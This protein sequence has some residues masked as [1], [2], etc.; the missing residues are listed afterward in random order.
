MK[1]KS[2][3]N[4]LTFDDFANYIHRIVMP[5][6]KNY[7]RCEIVEDRYFEGSLKEGIRNNRGAG[8][9]KLIFNDESLMPKDFR[10]NFFANSENKE[11]LN[12]VLAKEFVDFDRN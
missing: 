4:C 2:R 7:E 12:I 6:S 1:S 9:S 11:N 10:S 8:G 3:S 5:M